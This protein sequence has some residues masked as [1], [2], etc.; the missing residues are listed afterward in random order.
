MQSA[1]F[2][3]RLQSFALDAGAYTNIVSFGRDRN[4]NL[5]IVD[6]DG[7]ISC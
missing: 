6:F 7:E 1:S 3:D 2:T 4:N 5:Y